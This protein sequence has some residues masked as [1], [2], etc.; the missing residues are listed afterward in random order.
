MERPKSVK[1][2]CPHCKRAWEQDT[3]KLI[4]KVVIT[5]AKSLDDHKTSRI[6]CPN[7]D[8]GVNVKI[9]RAWLANEQ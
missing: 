3:N 1:L 2:E 6:D 5:I 9:P 4:E 7:C 8:K